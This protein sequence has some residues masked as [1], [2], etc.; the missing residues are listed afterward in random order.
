TYGGQSLF[1][2]KAGTEV[3]KGVSLELA[4]GTT[5]GIVGESGCGKSTL[6]RVIAGLLPPTSGDVE[7]EGESIIGLDRA[8][9]IEMRKRVQMVFQDPFG[10]LNPKRRVGS[11]I[12]DPFRIQKVAQGADRKNRVRE[13]ME[14]VGLN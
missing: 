4:R 10:S 8:R 7:I 3:L 1:G 9:W 12:G 5:L 14:I 2:R 11:I 6:A 13:L